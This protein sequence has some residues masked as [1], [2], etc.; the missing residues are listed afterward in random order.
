MQT[1]LGVQIISAKK[2]SEKNTAVG[3][4]QS[5]VFKEERLYELRV[6]YI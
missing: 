5:P 6:G 3:L 2:N 4:K 1:K